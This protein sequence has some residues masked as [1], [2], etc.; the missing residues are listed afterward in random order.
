MLCR[1]TTSAD[2][3]AWTKYY[4]GRVRAQTSGSW[5]RGRESFF[6]RRYELG[7]LLVGLGL[8]A[9]LPAAQVLQGTV[10][11]I[12]RDRDAKLL[13]Q[14]HDQIASSPAQICLDT[15]ESE[16]VFLG[17]FPGRFDSGQCTQSIY[18]AL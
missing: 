14:P 1:N 5:R 17:A 6:E 13:A 18:S 2:G 15:L 7:V 4:P 8:G 10:D 9:D 11:R 16:A 3:S 12:V